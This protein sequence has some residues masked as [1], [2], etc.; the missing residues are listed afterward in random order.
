MGRYSGIGARIRGGR[1]MPGADDAEVRV[2]RRVRRKLNFYRD[3]TLFVV[4]VGALALID[5]TTGEGWWVQW[6]AGIWGA[7]LALKFVGTFVG[8][9]LWGRDV[10]ERMVR[11]ELERRDR[12]PRPNAGDG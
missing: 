11:R 8:P 12:G 1:A 5:L 6:V 9:T 10:E 3:V 4:V 2:R 7:I